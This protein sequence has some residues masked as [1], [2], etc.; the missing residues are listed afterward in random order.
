MDCLI[1]YHS[2]F[3]SLGHDVT[4]VTSYCPI[5]TSDT[6][7]ALEGYFCQ[8]IV[9]YDITIVQYDI[10]IVAL[11]QRVILKNIARSIWYFESV[12]TITEGHVT[13]NRPISI[14]YLHLTYNNV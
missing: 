9:Q 11:W 12:C 7:V 10:T 8:T 1:Y 3:Y 2:M 14:E 4:I 13:R 5:M 6:M